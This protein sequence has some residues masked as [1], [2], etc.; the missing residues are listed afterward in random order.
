MG[1]SPFYYH[2]M[3]ILE[4]CESC[5]AVPGSASCPFMSKPTQ[6]RLQIAVSDEIKLVSVY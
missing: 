1:A 3:D 4:A 5:D 6:T 2:C